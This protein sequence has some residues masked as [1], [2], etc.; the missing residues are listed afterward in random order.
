MDEK[1]QSK[2][3]TLVKYP[4]PKN[5]TFQNFKKKLQKDAHETSTEK[6]NKKVN[7]NSD[8]SISS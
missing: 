8:Y 5:R 4:S 6:I 1:L 3:F 7:S 2:Q